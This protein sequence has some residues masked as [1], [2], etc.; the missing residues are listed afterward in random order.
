MTKIVNLQKSSKRFGLGEIGSPAYTSQTCS[1]C[2]YVDKE[3]RKSR[4]EFECKLCGSLLFS[5]LSL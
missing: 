4:S 5:C 1:N 2:G 3:N